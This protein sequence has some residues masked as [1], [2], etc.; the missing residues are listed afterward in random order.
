[1]TKLSILRHAATCLMVVAA[2]LIFSAFPSSAADVKKDN[3]SGRAGKEKGALVENKREASDNGK[4]VKDKI[5]P[6]QT[7]KKKVV[8]KAVGTAAVGVA[9][10]KVTTAV[11]EGMQKDE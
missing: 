9:A 2:L 5:E 11:V 8:K 3:L 4:G 7:V 1:M 6:E 10:K